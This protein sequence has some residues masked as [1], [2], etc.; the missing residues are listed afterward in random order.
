MS[1]INLKEIAQPEH[2][3]RHFLI[4]RPLQTLYQNVTYELSGM[5]TDISPLA[6]KLE[7]KS[8]TI[9]LSVIRCRESPLSFRL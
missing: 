9:A 8:L 7:E 6:V 5:C 4:R 2:L 3:G 1:L